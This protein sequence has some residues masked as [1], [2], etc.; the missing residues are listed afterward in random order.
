MCY[1][2]IIAPRKIFW[3]TVCF[4]FILLVNSNSYYNSSNSI[5]KY[6]I[7]QILGWVFQIASHKYFEGNSPALLEGA[8]Q[9]F[10]TA[11]IFI[12]D[13]INQNLPEINFGLITLIYSIYKL[14]Y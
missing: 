3:Q 9:S 10:V 2:Y 14:L 6:L 1:Y 12:V 7:V 11:P 13:E 8:V 4:Y 5:T